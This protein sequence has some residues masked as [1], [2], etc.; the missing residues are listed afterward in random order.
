MKPL[1][2]Y[3]VSCEGQIQVVQAHYFTYSRQPKG[4]ELFVTNEEGDDESTAYFPKFSWIIKQPEG[5]PAP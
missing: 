4:L 3:H 1:N 5:T 2:T